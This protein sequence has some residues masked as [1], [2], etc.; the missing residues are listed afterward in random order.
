MGIKSVLVRPFIVALVYVLTLV[1][2][3]YIL[4]TENKRV[5]EVFIPNGA[6]VKHGPRVCKNV[7]I[8]PGVGQSI[9]G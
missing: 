3:V 7:E 6:T 4:S 9:Q 1:T 8:K 5:P 2:L